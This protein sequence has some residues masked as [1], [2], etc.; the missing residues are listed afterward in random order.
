MG[1]SS[2]R[3]QA[4]LVVAVIF[5]LGMDAQVNWRALNMCASFHGQTTTDMEHSNITPMPMTHGLKHEAAGRRLWATVHLSRCH[6]CT[7]RYI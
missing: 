6:I 4:R 7:V 2:S 3:I 5:E 1:S